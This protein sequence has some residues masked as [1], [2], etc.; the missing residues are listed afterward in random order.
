MTYKVS[1]GAL[2][3]VGNSVIEIHDIDTI[4]GAP[5]YQMR[6]NIKG[7][8]PFA[9]LDNTYQ[10]WFDMEGLFSRRYRQDT[11]EV[12]KKRKRSYEF[13]LSE[14]R[15]RRLDLS[16]T[17][18]D[19]TGVMPTDQPL[20]DLSFL[21]FARTLPL[22]VGQTYT[23]PRYFREDGNPVVLKV[24]RKD[25]IDLRNLGQFATIVV[26]PIIETD[27]L[28]SQ[29]GNAEVHFTDDDRRIPVYIK[30]GVSSV[31]LLKTL[32]MELVRYEPGRRL[33]PPFKPGKN[34]GQ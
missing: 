30:A 33:S 31:P 24:L 32:K 2:R 18:K 28:F 9:H 8:I 16:P 34:S 27:G 29:G 12:G 5:T 7:G 25:R 19:Y 10:S 3:Q 13:S 6:M 11:H 22:V 21:Y 26:Q 17:N 15:W 20:D 14:K 1:V 23:L 4:Q